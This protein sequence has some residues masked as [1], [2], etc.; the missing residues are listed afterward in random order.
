MKKRWL[1]FSF[2]AIVGFTLYYF[3]GWPL[4]RVGL[5]WLLEPGA[6]AHRFL[7]WKLGITTAFLAGVIIN[8]ITYGLLVLGVWQLFR[9]VSRRLWPESPDQPNPAP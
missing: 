3:C 6:I 5:L 9:P 4:N 2:G 1:V 8:S 7:I